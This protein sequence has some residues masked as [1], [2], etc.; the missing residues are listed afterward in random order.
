MGDLS[1]EVGGQIDDVNRIERA[2]LGA[3]TAS[4]AETF[5]DEGDSRGRVDF[6]AEL[7]S[8]DH[9]A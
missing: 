9:W 5:G 3:D 8:T 2:F 6:D 7:A 1:L 4:Y